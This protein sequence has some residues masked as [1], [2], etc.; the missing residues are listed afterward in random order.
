MQEYVLYLGLRCTSKK[1]KGVN[2][3]QF[4]LQMN[5]NLF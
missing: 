3:A 4:H 2:P 1:S 5:T